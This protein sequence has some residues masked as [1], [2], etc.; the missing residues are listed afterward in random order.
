[1]SAKNAAKERAHCE[2]AADAWLGRLLGDSTTLA[3][4]IERAREAARQQ[5]VPSLAKL[6]AENKRL[7]WQLAGVNA[8]CA[9]P[10]GSAGD[11]TNHVGDAYVLVSTLQKALKT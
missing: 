5:M 6:R 10:D 7:H 9:V 3:Q 1:M 11:G 8:L 4:V 2:A